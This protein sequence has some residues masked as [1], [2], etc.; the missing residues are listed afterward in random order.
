MEPVTALE[1]ACTSFRSRLAVVPPEAWDR[2]SSCEGWSIGDVVD[3]VIGGNR[4]AVA[5]LDGATVEEAMDA[6][7]RP[8][9][10]GARLE[11]HDESARA[12][13]AAFTRGLD[14]QVQHP[15]G[16]MSGATFC[17]LRIGD[18]ALH[19]W[20]LSRSLGQDA[21]DDDVAAV[22]L[23]AYLDLLG[24][25]VPEGPG[26]PGARLLALSGRSA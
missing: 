10:E 20:D 8:G 13:I 18:V 22:A 25:A 26:P 3:H 1:R 6:A 23:P 15:A 17:R 7:R 4:F 21:V 14:R 9:F 11:L 5:V 2:A 16:A 12:Q 24:T 19:G